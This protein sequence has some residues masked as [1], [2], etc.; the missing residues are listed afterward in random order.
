MLQGSPH[1]IFV[2]LGPDPGNCRQFQGTLLYINITAYHKTIINTF[3]W[4][5]KNVNED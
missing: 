1:Y 5:S 4:R 2:S 3:L